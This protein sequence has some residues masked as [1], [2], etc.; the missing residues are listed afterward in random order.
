MHIYERVS[1]KQYTT[2][3]DEAMVHIT[4]LSPELQ[5][6]IQN[7]LE[8]QKIH[9]EW[10]RALTQAYRYLDVRDHRKRWPIHVNVEENVN[11]EDQV[12]PSCSAPTLQKA[13]ELQRHNQVI[14]GLDYYNPHMTPAD[15][16]SISHL[17]GL[18]RLG[19]CNYNDGSPSIAL[20]PL[21][22]LNGCKFLRKL[23]L[24]R[25]EDTCK[26]LLSW[27]SQLTYLKFS[28]H[29]GYDNNGDI[30]LDR[31]ADYHKYL[32]ELIVT[33]CTGDIISNAPDPGAERFKVLETFEINN[34]EGDINGGLAFLGRC[35][36]LKTLTLDSLGLNSLPNLCNCP[37][38][39]EVCITYS[40]FPD[41]EWLRDC[42]KLKTLTLKCCDSFEE[43]LTSLETHQILDTLT[44][45]EE[46]DIEQL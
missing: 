29:A 23:N 14:T 3:Q 33:G 20:G 41:I 12:I 39:T 8:G 17:Y 45:L 24:H 26:V 27:V 19:I 42:T 4:D 32:K 30:D 28:E 2:N 44:S 16:E 7:L 1:H 34:H 40:V 43:M 10:Y 21:N 46:C 11:V 31:V 18:S 5:D 13:I 9:Q 36:G 37:E 15:L 22:A 25:C 38:L 35:K 6:T